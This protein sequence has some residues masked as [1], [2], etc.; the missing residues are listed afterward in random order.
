MKA[1]IKEVVSVKPHTGNFGTTQYHCLVMENG[2]KIN[3]GKKTIQ[4]VG[5]ELNYEITETG[6]Q[7]FNKAKS[8]QDEEHPMTKQS[9]ASF[10]SDFNKVDVQDNILYQVCLKGAMDFYLQINQA[11]IEEK[12]GYN[13][14]NICSMALEVAMQ[15]KKDIEILKKI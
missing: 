12:Y 15:S 11:G 2:D 4:Q 14:T 6:Q 5:W 3:I 13:A 7:E 10:K 9:P 1:K 8:I